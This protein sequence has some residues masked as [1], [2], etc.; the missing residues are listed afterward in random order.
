MLKTIKCILTGALALGILTCA[1]NTASAYTDEDF[2]QLEKLQKNLLEAEASVFAP[3]NFT[4]YQK[5]HTKLSK[6][7]RQNAKANKIDKALE[8]CREF[9]ENALKAV[10]VTKK[11]LA[12]YLAPREKAVAAKAPSLQPSLFNKGEV[13]FIKATGKIERGDIKSGLKEVPKALP[14]FDRAE[15]EAIRSQVLNEADKLIAAAEQDQARKYALITLDKATSHR[16]KSSAVIDADR[17][18]RSAAEAEAMLAEY[19]ARHATELSQRVRSLKKNDQ[20]W[21]QIMLSYE[22]FMQ[23]A[24]DGRNLKLQFDRGASTAA[25]QLSGE[26]VMLTDSIM[27]LDA[28]QTDF[29]NRVTELCSRLGIEYDNS[30]QVPAASAALEALESE[31]GSLVRDLD[32]VRGEV[33]LTKSD[34]ERTQQEKET[35]S[36]ILAVKQAQERRFSETRALFTPTEALTLYNASGDVVIRLRGLTFSSG[37]FELEDRHNDL[38]SKVTKALVTYEGS[39]VIIEGHTDNTGSSGVNRSLSEKRAL[40]VMNYLRQSTGRP[41][42]DFKAIGYGAEKPVAN[43]QSKQGRAENRRIDIVIL[44]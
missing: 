18:D 11:A 1:S 19:E 4:E 35:A 32:D 3:K 6:L 33:R 30:G 14:H 20:A 44:R 39:Q 29:R 2:A 36:A 34:L 8:K 23:Q 38:L 22:I 24:A 31:F 15:L 43:N 17:Y 41:A 25:R 5:H 26:M 21:E 9:G 13:L 7:R 42:S 27:S 28:A 16:A 12:E 40:S 10:D 37:R